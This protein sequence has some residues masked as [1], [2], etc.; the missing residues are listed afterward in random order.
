MLLHSSFNI[1]PSSTVNQNKIQV[2]GDL[3]HQQPTA[4]NL[5]RVASSHLA[6]FV[7]PPC[8]LVRAT[9]TK[10]KYAIYSVAPQ[11]NIITN[12]NLICVRFQVKSFD[13]HQVFVSNWAAFILFLLSPSVDK[14]LHKY[15]S[16]KFIIGSSRQKAHYHHL[17]TTTACG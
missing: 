10:L 14:I 5:A 12:S 15:L 7:D 3:G 4:L 2:N 11:V 13:Q 17:T 6:E 9:Q 8:Y 1:V 16:K